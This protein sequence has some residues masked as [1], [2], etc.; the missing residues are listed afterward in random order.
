MGVRGLK[1]HIHFMQKINITAKN[2]GK[3]F[4]YEWI[5][6]NVDFVWENGQ[7]YAIIGGNGSGKSTILHLLAGVTSPSEGDITYIS[8]KKHFS[9]E[10]IFYH[11]NWVAPYIDLIEELNLKEIFAF[12]TKFKTIP[13][14]FTDWADNI[15]IPKK[16]HETLLK[17]YSS[18]MKQRV[19]LGLAFASESP[20][21][22][23]D[24]PTSNLDTAGIDWYRNCIL[25]QNIQNRLCI[26]A[27]NQIHEYDF[28]EKILAINNFQG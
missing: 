26:I 13:Q 5:F 22:L 9:P 16:R 12:H 1:N 21:L 24:E 14:K 11:I 6:K 20:I 18:G 15:Q 28:C 23:L 27:S 7:K 4:Q 19:K 2:L 10:N 3:K 8:Q 17:L 25:D